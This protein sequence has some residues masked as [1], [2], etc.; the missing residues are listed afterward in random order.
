VWHYRAAGTVGSSG[1]NTKAMENV[2]ALVTRGSVKLSDLGGK[3]Y[4]L[5]DIERDGAE[6]FFTDRHLRPALCPW[7]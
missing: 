6:P 7:G 4:T 2:L 1:C 5:S 3:T